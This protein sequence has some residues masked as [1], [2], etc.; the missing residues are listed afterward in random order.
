MIEKR[1]IQANAG[2]VHIYFFNHIK[3]ILDIVDYRRMAL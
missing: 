1:Q 2:I 3:E